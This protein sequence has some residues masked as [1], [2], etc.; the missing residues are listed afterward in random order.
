MRLDLAKQFHYHPGRLINLLEML[1]WV[2]LFP[3]EYLS[4][5]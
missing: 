4:N 1:L 2:I 5:G 3:D